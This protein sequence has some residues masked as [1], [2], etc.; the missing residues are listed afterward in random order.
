MIFKSI[1]SASNLVWLRGVMD[2]ALDFG[3][4]GCGF[5]SHRGQ[6]FP[7]LFENFWIGLL[8]IVIIILLLF[9]A[10]NNNQF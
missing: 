1:N 7:H 5:K 4:K 8:H 3:S 10:C 9:H 2:S 6:F